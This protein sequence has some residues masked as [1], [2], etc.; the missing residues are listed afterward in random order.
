MR[1]AMVTSSAADAL[2]FMRR[3]AP[4]RRQGRRAPGAWR[5]AGQ[6]HEEREGEGEAK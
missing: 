2:A 1:A 3:R 5:G 6:K 4:D